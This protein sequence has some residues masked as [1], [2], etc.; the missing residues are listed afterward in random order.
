[1]LPVILWTVTTGK[2]LSKKYDPVLA[3]FAAFMLS[4]VAMVTLGDIHFGI[5]VHYGSSHIILIP[6]FVTQ[7]LYLI[8][9]IINN[10]KL[11][12]TP[13]IKHEEICT[14]AEDRGDV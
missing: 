9:I 7:P 2:P 10:F 13:E 5:A 1:M 12:V 11:P 6:L 14:I 3:Y 4:F 8:S